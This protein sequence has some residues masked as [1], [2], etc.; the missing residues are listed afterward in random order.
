MPSYASIMVVLVL[1]SPI[2][3]SKNNFSK[4]LC[5][6]HP[7]ITTIVINVNQKRTSMILG[8]RN[9]VLYGKGY[10]EDVLCGLRF[11]ISPSSFYQI[12]PA[13]TEKLYGKAIEFAGL[14]GK[15]R[16]IDAYCGIGTIGM[17][18]APKAGEVIGVEL[19]KDAVK[20]AIGNAKL[21]Q[22]KNIR[23]YNED[24][25]RFMV[26]MAQEHEKA[27]VVFMDP[28]RSGSTPE[29]I[30]AVNMLN[31][32]RVVYVSCDPTTLQRDLEIFR[33]KGWKVKKV[34]PVDMFPYTK[35]IESIALLQRMSNTRSKE[36]TLDVDMEDYHRI[37]SEGR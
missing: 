7:E 24:A 4:E 15:E 9:I 29:F 36:I 26:R 10:I 13:Q 20:D 25:S 35:H 17:C 31:P 34:Q 30:D 3:P 6:L 8:E 2:M 21:N 11:K 37:K 12:N 14:T 28:P 23:F 22:L 33:K 1:S 18:A 32:K 16:V 27:D 19:N 5:R